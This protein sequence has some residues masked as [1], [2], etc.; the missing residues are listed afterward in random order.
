MKK[1][2]LFFIIVMCISVTNTLLADDVY[3]TISN[4]SGSNTNDGKILLYLNGGIA[5]YSFTWSGSNGFSSSSKDVLNLA[6]G[7]YS[8]TITDGLCG[9][10]ILNNLELRAC[11]FS[12][13]HEI[14]ATCGTSTGSVKINFENGVAPYAIKWSYSSRFGLSIYDSETSLSNLSVGNYSVTLKDGAGCLVNMPFS[15]ETSPPVQVNQALSI[16][17]CP[18]NP[19]GSVYIS[20]SGSPPYQFNWD[21]G[22]TTQNLLDV[23]PGSY[24]LEI[25]DNKNCKFSNSFTV[26]TE[27]SSF[28][29]ITQ[30]CGYQ[31]FCKGVSTIIDA[32]TYPQ[33]NNWS[34]SIDHICSS[35]GQVVYS[36]SAPLTW[37]TDYFCGCCSIN[38]VCSISG[39]V[40]GT[41]NCGFH[42]EYSNNIQ[43]CGMIYLV[44]NCTGQRGFYSQDPGCGATPDCFPG[45]KE[46]S[47]VNTNL[48][49]RTKNDYIYYLDPITKEN[50]AFTF[51]EIASK[52]Y[53]TQYPKLPDL[54]LNEKVMYKNEN[55]TI[56]D[57]LKPKKLLFSV[58]PNPF[59]GSP[60][61]SL[62]ASKT[63]KENKAS[64]IV[65]DELGR[66]LLT[67]EINNLHEGE[68][69][70]KPNLSNFGSGFYFITIQMQDKKETKKVY[71][72]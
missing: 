62:Y 67:D 8:V 24:N 60:N 39:E 54:D 32:G 18:A 51:D 7:L 9:T 68:N 12:E 40:V 47:F 23:L 6:A 45:P 46:D 50:Y 27:A 35:T 59:E 16:K 33:N 57:V 64:L 63:S 3:A 44:C 29:P 26:G 19:D 22:Y 71:K 58:S 10:A 38:L 41:S 34:C 49:D 25:K 56:Y 1:N 13:T 2:T 65:S 69:F 11:T 52:K 4:P 55:M 30:P 20:V 70:I 48:I 37:Q 14:T 15:I 5:P 61:I 17:S 66:V 21:N 72:K 43:C 53:K 42:L 36:E 31:S 28:I